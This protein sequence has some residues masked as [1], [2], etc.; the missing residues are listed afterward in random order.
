[1]TIKSPGYIAPG[2]VYVADEVRSRL[3]IG[4]WA[5]RSMRRAGLRVRY[6]GGRA[7]VLGDDVIE[8]FKTQ[9]HQR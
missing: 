9:S 8:F 2:H 3:R 5:W 6:V 1:M 4:A 7:Y